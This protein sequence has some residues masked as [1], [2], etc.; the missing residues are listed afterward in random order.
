MSSSRSDAEIWLRT[1]SDTC[2]ST[3]RANGARCGP[4]NVM[5]TIGLLAP[6]LLAQRHG[7]CPWH[8]EVVGQ[9][10]DFLAVAVQRRDVVARADIRPVLKHGQDARVD[11]LPL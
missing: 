6:G 8:L 7:R 3:H 1:G 11:I 10:L 4:M 9:T 2:A 5:S